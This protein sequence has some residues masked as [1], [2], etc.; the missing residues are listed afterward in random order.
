MTG[1]SGKYYYNVDTKGRVMIPAPFRSTILDSSCSKLY[2]TSAIFD[3]CLCLYPSEE[4]ER[5]VNKVRSMPVMK[6]SVM[7]LRRR[8]VA[9][10]QECNIDRHGRVLIPPAHRSDAKISGEVVIVGQ[11]EKMEVWSRAEWD[12][13]VDP[14]RI[15]TGAYKKELETLF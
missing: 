15:D 3:T 8:V 1:F 13:V 4:W 6:E 10:A 9:S 11:I 7:W 14:G 12:A 2:I 5:F